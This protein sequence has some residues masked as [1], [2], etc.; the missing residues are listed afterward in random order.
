VQ[1]S[2]RSLATEPNGVCS[3][4]TFQPTRFKER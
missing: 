2:I 3:S 1:L 4:E